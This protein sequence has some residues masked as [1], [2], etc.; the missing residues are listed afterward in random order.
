[1]NQTTYLQQREGETIPELAKRIAEAHQAMRTK[2]P[3]I[4]SRAEA[5]ERG[6]KYYFTGNPCV[7]GEVAARKTNDSSCLCVKCREAARARSRKWDKNNQKLK[8]EQ[9]KRYRRNNPEKIKERNE[10]YYQENKEKISAYKREYVKDNADRI[11]ENNRKYYEDNIDLL[12]HKARVYRESNAENLRNKRELMWKTNKDILA[13]RSRL[14]R[15]NNKSYVHAR[16]KS[17]YASNKEKFRASKAKR[18]SAKRQAIPLWFSEFDHFA[19]QQAYELA[20]ERKQETGIE[21]HVDHMIPLR[22]RKCCGLHC[23]D[24]IQVIPAVMNLEKNNKMQL[25]KPL[26]WLR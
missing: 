9:S 22:A 15:Q 24:N 2:Q 1:M 25:T 11:K 16:N 6:L 12:R 17:Y 18:R 3:E 21:W 19:F 14:W 13:E 20:A 4:I 7:R 23:A 10:R 8:A 5:K 26:E